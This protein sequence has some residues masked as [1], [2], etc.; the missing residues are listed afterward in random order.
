MSFY[1]RMSAAFDHVLVYEKPELQ[2][3]ARSVIP[4]DRLMKQAQA[5]YGASK[6][7]ILFFVSILS[8]AP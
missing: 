8:F 5:K 3:K 7:S 6:V 2:E 1:E 4:R